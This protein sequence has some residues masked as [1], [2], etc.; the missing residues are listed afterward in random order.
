MQWLP[1]FQKENQIYNLSGVCGQ[2]L[3]QTSG[4]PH[5]QMDEVMTSGATFRGFYAK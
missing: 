1:Y 3:L 5:A 2:I 4:G